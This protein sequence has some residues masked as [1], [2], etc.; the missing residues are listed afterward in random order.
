MLPKEIPRLPTLDIDVYMKTA[1][2]VGGD[3]YDFDLT[4]DGTLTIALGDATGH[5]TKAGVMVA[6]IKSLFNTMA[7]TFYS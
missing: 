2:E 1:S 6:L 5:G 7:N 4:S 3:Y